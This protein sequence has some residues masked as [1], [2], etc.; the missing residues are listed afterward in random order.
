MTGI[1]RNSHVV[2]MAAFAPLFVHINHTVTCP[3]NLI[4]FDGSR[5]EG[6]QLQHHSCTEQ[7]RRWH[8]CEQ[9]DRAV[10]LLHSVVMLKVSCTV[11]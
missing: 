9:A 1:E 7:P 4:G 11:G 6:P 3:S 2:E 5:W 10:C 8:C